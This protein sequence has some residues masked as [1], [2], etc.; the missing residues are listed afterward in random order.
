MKLAKSSAWLSRSI[1]KSAFSLEIQFTMLIGA[2]L[3]CFGRRI[4][5][6]ARCFGRRIKAFARCFGRRIKAFA[7]CFGRMYYLIA[8]RE[9]LGEKRRQS[10]SNQISS[11]WPGVRQW[12]LCPARPGPFVFYKAHCSQS[13]SFYRSA[14]VYYW[15]IERRRHGG[16]AHGSSRDHRDLP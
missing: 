6:F 16:V 7:R 5:A 10:V 15:R 11:A 12:H 9:H 1:A 2:V 8:F 13:V 3:S 4:K 14:T